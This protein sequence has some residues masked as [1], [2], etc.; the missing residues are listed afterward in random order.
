MVG[1]LLPLYLLLRRCGSPFL[2]AFH[3]P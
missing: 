2:M 3:Q 1:D